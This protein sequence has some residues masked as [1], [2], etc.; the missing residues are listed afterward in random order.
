[1]N[2]EELETVATET[3]AAE[4]AAKAPANMKKFKILLIVDIVLIVGLF[5]L[6]MCMKSSYEEQA[7][8]SYDT[9]MTAY[10][11]SV[12]EVRFDL[13]KSVDQYNMAWNLVYATLNSD[14]SLASFQANVK[15]VEEN[16][17]A[18]L[19][20]LTYIYRNA[21]LNMYNS[22][23]II[24][25]ALAEY[26]ERGLAE[27]FLVKD[28]ASVKEVACGKGCVVTFNFDGKKLKSVDYEALKKINMTETF[29]VGEPA[30]FHFE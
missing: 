27:T 16:K 17:D 25:K 8:S 13:W 20:Q 26:G 18:R 15:A 12:D 5:I 23:T 11:S 14:K 9:Q 30:P 10:K 6:M 7:K 4:T 2:N 19:T 1:M 3:D 22:E 29:K 21:L 24:N 28:E